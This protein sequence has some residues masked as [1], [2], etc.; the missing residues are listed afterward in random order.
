[1]TTQVVPWQPTTLPK[2]WHVVGADMYREVPY[3]A[4]ASGPVV[5]TMRLTLAHELGWRVE[6]TAQSYG[7][8]QGQFNEVAI[9]AYL[10]A[11][12][13]TGGMLSVR[14]LDAEYDPRW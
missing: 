8:E 1:M 12:T 4:Y 6:M 9:A 7:D 11:L 2:G 10:N 5:N 13:E 3:G 14:R